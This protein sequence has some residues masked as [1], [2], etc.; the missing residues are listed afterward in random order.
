MKSVY[1][2]VLLEADQLEC[3]QRSSPTQSQEE[4]CV[5]E[6]A[7]TRIV[8]VVPICALS[9]VPAIHW[10][11]HNI[12][13]V[14]GIIITACN[15]GLQP[16]SQ[17]VCRGVWAI[18]WVI[19]EGDFEF[20]IEALCSKIAEVFRDKAEGEDVGGGGLEREG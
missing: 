5:H 18:I 6:L 3:L 11:Q 13:Q 8:H 17:D 7:A 4:Q 1:G 19:W 10:L 9:F 12:S 16:A 15:E 2:F 20:S 14:F